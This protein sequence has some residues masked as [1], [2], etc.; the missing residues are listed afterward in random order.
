MAVRGFI[1]SICGVPMVPRIKRLELPQL[2]SPVVTYSRVGRDSHRRAMCDP[3][4]SRV[5][6]GETV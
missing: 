3:G 4:S 5:V 2:C 1:S 6:S